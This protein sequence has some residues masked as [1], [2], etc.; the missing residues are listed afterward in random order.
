MGRSALWF[1]DTPK[2]WPMPDQFRLMPLMGATEQQ[3]WDDYFCYLK[4]LSVISPI[5]N[6]AKVMKYGRFIKPTS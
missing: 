4:S 1:W 5:I 2:V 3:A 6:Q